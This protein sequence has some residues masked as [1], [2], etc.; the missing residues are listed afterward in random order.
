MKPS[1]LTTP[2]QLADCSFTTG[3][4]QISAVERRGHSTLL[5]LSTMGLC[6]L[7]GLLV[8]GVL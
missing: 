7:A 3:H 4:S 8:A 2:R 1:H 6:V 5:V